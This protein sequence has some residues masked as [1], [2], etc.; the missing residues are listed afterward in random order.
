MNANAPGLSE[1]QVEAALPSFGGLILGSL[2]IEA[3][4]QTDPPVELDCGDPTRG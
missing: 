3:E 1:E 2:G 4:G